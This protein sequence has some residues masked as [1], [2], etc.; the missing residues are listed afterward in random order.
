MNVNICF[1]ERCLSTDSSYL[2]VRNMKIYQ[3]RKGTLICNFK[4][5]R[6]L[7][8]HY[9]S[10]VSSDFMLNLTLFSN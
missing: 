6:N 9:I 5:C 1:H 2:D 7:I 3:K 8:I 10:D 4:D